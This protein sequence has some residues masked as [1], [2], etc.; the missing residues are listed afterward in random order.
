MARA[1]LQLCGAW[2][3]LL[4]R[5]GSE[6]DVRLC[7]RSALVR[8]GGVIFAL[9]QQAVSPCQQGAQPA[10]WSDLAVPELLLALL[11]LR[12]SEG[13]VRPCVSAVAPSPV[14]TSSESV[15]VRRR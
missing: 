8:R 1:R 5:R 15:S 6:G 7:Q 13:D 12:G 4:F 9:R 14:Q 10:S 2:P 3:G 11:L